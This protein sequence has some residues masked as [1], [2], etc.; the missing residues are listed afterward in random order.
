MI[1]RERF[2][3][4]DESSPPHE[5]DEILDLLPAEVMLNVPDQTL[6]LW[7]PPGPLTALWRDP[8]STRHKIMRVAVD[9]SFDIGPMSVRGSSTG[10]TEDWPGESAVFDQWFE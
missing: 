4:A 3:A 1:D 8:H 6:S 2:P 10:E 7:F 5:I 9:A